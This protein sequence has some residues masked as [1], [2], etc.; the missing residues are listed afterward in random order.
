MRNSLIVAHR[1]YRRYLHR[2]SRREIAGKNSGDNY[3]CR[4]RKGYAQIDRRIAEC[5]YLGNDITIC[6]LRSRLCSLH[7]IINQFCEANPHHHP[8]ISEDGC[9]QYGF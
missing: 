9:N 4:R 7:P 5:A 2:L 6:C 1:L 8:E 3:Q